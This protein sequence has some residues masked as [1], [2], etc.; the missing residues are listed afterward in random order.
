MQFSE[1]DKYKRQYPAL[2]LQLS[3]LES[4]LLDLLARPMSP[5]V[6]PALVAKKV[7][8]DEGLALALLMLAQEADLIEPRYVI[9]CSETENFLS[10]YRSLKKVPSKVFCP[11]HDREHGSGDYY[12]EL[13]F[14]FT[15][16]AMN[17]YAETATKE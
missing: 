6:V 4:Y 10:E 17:K 8:S 1:L 3:I 2:N 14:R 15:P 9:Y 12:V 11:Y 16:R 13:T 5:D 7:S